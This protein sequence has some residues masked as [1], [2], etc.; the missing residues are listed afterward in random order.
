MRIRGS[1]LLTIVAAMM[2]LFIG[3][4]GGDDKGGVATL[5]WNP[6]ISS[7]PI[8]YTV[9][10]GKQP[11]ASPGACTYEHSVD[12]QEPQAMITSLD[13]NTDYYFAVSAFNGAARSLCSAEVTKRTAILAV[14]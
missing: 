10:Y 5:S 7:S 9:H 8:S 1:L 2:A 13:L 11:S 14:R 6:V 4:G 12:V 3:C